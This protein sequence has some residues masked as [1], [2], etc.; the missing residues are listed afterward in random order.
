MTQPASVL[1]DG[2]LKVAW[3]PAIA[4]PEHPTVAEL[5]AGG[6]ID[7]SCY[8]TSDG[9][10]PT[11]DEGTVTDDRLCSRQTFEKPGRITDKL[12]LKYVY[13][14]QAPTA[15]D[16]KA[17]TTLL[18]LTAGF[19]VSRWGAAFETDFA[20]D[21][22]VDAYPAQCG[23]Q[24]KQPPEANGVLKISQK[25]FVSNTIAEDVAVVA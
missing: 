21:D 15:A 7:L 17:K 5:T 20:A 19:V 16:N 9:F 23:K 2:N 3:V 25:I 10:A 4:D 1:A 18:H 12:D 8:L 6:C 22:I 11:A 24:M 13:Q 14:G